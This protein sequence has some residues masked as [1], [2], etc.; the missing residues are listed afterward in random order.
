MNLDST[1]HM[2]VMRARVR[3]DERGFVRIFGVIASHSRG[4]GTPH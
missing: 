1:L 2:P 3:S 4:I